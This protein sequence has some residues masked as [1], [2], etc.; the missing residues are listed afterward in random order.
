MD[1]RSG[2]PYPTMA[3]IPFEE[4]KANLRFFLLLF[5]LLVDSL[6]E[7]LLSLKSASVENNVGEFTTQEM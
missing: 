5:L 3:L 4:R 2:T 6:E 7:I 1:R